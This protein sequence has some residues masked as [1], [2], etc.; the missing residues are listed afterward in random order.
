VEE[1]TSLRKQVRE[2]EKEIRRLKE[3]NE[4]LEEAIGDRQEQSSNTKGQ[5]LIYQIPARDVIG[6]TA[7]EVIAAFGEPEIYAENDSMEYG[8]DGSDGSYKFGFCAGRQ[9]EII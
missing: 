9:V 6:M 2:L 5:V 8:A 3:E 1:V 4:F 7:D